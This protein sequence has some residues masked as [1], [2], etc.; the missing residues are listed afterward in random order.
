MTTNASSIFRVRERDPVQ[1]LNNSIRRLRR[2]LLAQIR[3]LHILKA[4]NDEAFIDDLLVQTDVLRKAYD[5]ELHVHS[6][7]TLRD[8]Y[9]KIIDIKEGVRTRERDYDNEVF[10]KYERI[11]DQISMVAKWTFTA[12]RQKI[13]LAI[14][15]QQCA[16][17]T[18][19]G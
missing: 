6:L 18:A 16:D 2:K 15:A 10:S 9:I 5:R 13:N 12:K 1:S 11:T 8:I 3:A 19:S 14:D 17:N 7:T 4:Q